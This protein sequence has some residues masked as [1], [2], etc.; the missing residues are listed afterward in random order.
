VGSAPDWLTFLPDSRR[1]FVSNAGSDSVS[2][3][4]MASFHELSRIPV[5]KVPKRLIAAD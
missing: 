4:D 1:C 3:I 2:V 5:G